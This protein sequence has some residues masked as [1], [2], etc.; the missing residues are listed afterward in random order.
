M[1]CLLFLASL[2]SSSSSSVSEVSTTSLLISGGLMA[3]IAVVRL[4]RRKDR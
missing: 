2:P 3:L 4:V 1:Y